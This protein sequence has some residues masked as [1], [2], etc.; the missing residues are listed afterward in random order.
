[1]ACR[2]SPVRARLAPSTETPASA[3]VSSFS[4]GVC[5]GASGR[6][7]C[8]LAPGKAG[9]RSHLGHTMDVA[10]EVLEP[11][12]PVLAQL[13][14]PL[15]VRLDPTTVDLL[16]PDAAGGELV[17]RLLEVFHLPGGDRAA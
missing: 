1:M 14:D 5:R 4:G 16:E 17:H 2:R 13:G 11:G 10:V 9:G 12:H 15:L 6:A 3:G 7:S 8:P